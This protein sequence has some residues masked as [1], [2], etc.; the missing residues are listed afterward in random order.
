MSL[1]QRLKDAEQDR[2]RAAEVSGEDGG[3]DSNSNV[4]DLSDVRSAAEQAH[5]SGA[6]PSQPLEHAL[7]DARLTAVAPTG[8]AYDPVRNGDASSAFH[9]PDPIT[10]DRASNYECP[11][12]GGTTQ[13]DLIDQVHHTVSLSCLDCFHM[14]RLEQ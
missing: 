2:Q 8:I 14:F 5:G 6:G 4:I 3:Q 10:L 13:V 1:S 9:D 11:R 12:C 7:R